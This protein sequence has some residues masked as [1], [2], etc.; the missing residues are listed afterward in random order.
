MRKIEMF[1]LLKAQNHHGNKETETGG[2]ELELSGPVE[3]RSSFTEG[4]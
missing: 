4:H 2:L 1:R 3:T